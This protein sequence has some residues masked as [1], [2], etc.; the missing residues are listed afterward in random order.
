MTNFI[1]LD[2]TKI[3]IN[4]LGEG[5]LEAIEDL[6]NDNRPDLF[7]HVIPNTRIWRTGIEQF[8]ASMFL[9]PEEPC[10]THKT[11]VDGGILTFIR[12]ALVEK[13][14]DY[15]DPN[16]PLPDGQQGENLK[17]EQDAVNVLSA[18]NPPAGTDEDENI[19]PAD[20][21]DRLVAD[22]KGRWVTQ[23]EFT[24]ATINKIVYKVGTLK[25]YRTDEN[26]VKKSKKKPLMGLIEDP[27]I[28]FELIKKG[29]HKHS[30]N[31]YR[32]ILRSEFDLQRNC[33]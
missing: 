25:T 1:I 14:S 11:I 4:G 22:G 20:I 7:H 13:L 31:E 16:K 12:M 15:L 3:D 32:Y 28:I 24:D 10:P 23:R 27:G 9:D 29:D 8:P 17:G 6:C 33:Q 26:K 21:A 5:E 18:A 30:P 19:D 2:S